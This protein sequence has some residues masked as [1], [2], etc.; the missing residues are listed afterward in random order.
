MHFLSTR[1]LALAL[2]FGAG[3]T[4]LVAQT[5]VTNRNQITSPTT[6]TWDQAGS[7]LANP[8]TVALGFTNMTVSTNGNSWYGPCQAGSC[9]AGGFNNGDYLLMGWGSTSLSFTFS[10]LVS[11]FATQAWNNQCCGGP[12][13]LTAWRGGVQTAQYNYTTGGGAA[14]NNGQATTLG[15]IDASGFDRIDLTFGTETA[16]NDL[17]FGGATATPEPASM[18]LLASGLVGLGVIARRRRKA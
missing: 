15:I 2:A 14:A 13:Q 4:P 6:F 10:S 9:W 7:G 8:F 18:M 3:A 1:S 16:V 5:S 12:V 17:T 11:G